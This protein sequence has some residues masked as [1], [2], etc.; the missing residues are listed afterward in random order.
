MK[1]PFLDK[2]NPTPLQ[3][4]PTPLQMKK[5]TVAWTTSVGDQWEG[6]SDNEERVTRRKEWRGGRSGEENE[7]MEKKKNIKVAWG[8]T[9]ENL[10]HVRLNFVGIHFIL[11]IQT[12]DSQSVRLY[13]CTSI[14]TSVHMSICTSVHLYISLSVATWGAL[15][16]SGRLRRP[17]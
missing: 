3:K 13:I 8:R 1:N 5:N 6:R 10:S 11:T 12:S 9:V 15:R 7:K 16:N 4:K 17:Q 2:K 14:C